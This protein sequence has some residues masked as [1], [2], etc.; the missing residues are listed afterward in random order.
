[1]WSEDCTMTNELNLGRISYQLW[2]MSDMLKWGYEARPCDIY[3]PIFWWCDICR[4]IVGQRMFLSVC[5]VWWLSLE[6]WELNACCL[7]QYYVKGHL[8]NDMLLL[9]SGTSCILKIKASSQERKG[10]QHYTLI[11]IIIVKAYI[12]MI[13]FFK[14]SEGIKSFSS[15]VTLC[16][17]KGVQEGQEKN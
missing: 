10:E 1:M 15:A 6:I 9:G 11:F 13:D 7:W 2:L 8:S 12:C 5:L 17:G 14:W 3:L 16:V 4:S